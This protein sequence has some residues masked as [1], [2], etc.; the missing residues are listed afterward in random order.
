MAK[1]DSRPGDRAKAS[2]LFFS[3]KMDFVEM[4]FQHGL[5]HDA[6]VELALLNIVEFV[7]MNTGS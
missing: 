7:D 2:E 3:E 5:A 4:I 6:I 1:T